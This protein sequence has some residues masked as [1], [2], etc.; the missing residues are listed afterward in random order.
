LRARDCAV[1]FEE[2]FDE[3]SEARGVVVAHC[4]RISKCF[5]KEKM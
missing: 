2:N 4:F 5:K 3:L 1:R